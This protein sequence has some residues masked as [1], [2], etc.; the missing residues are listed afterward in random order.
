MEYYYTQP[1]NI[2]KD[3]LVITGDEAG[4][5]AKV[6]RKKADEEIY[7]TDGCGSLFRCNIVS[8]SKDNIS[9]SVLE[10]VD[11]TNEPKIE[12][13][14]YQSLLKNPDRF[15]FAIEK[16]VELGVWE[17]QPIITEHVISRSRAKTERW[18]AISLA[19]MKQSQ[20]V[21]LPKVSSPIMFID[22]IKNCTADLKLIAHEKA[23][24]SGLRN[25]DFGMEKTKTIAIMIG[26]EGGFSDEEVSL[27]IANGFKS[28][29]LGKRKF[30]SETATVASLSYIFL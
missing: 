25:L 9:C 5:L 19:A 22:A 7:V 3:S 1:E 4:H 2:N 17:I 24:D 18:N 29:S 14:L 11:E 10:K 15:E 27:A 8:T 20:R 16:S 26:P 6:L 23:G 30:R 13:T 12:V 28:I 21:H